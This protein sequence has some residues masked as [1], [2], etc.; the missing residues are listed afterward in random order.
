MVD[1]LRGFFCR[2]V[3]RKK[4]AKRSSFPALWFLIE[5]TIWFNRGTSLFLRADSQNDF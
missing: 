3:S 5:N 2:S 4:Y 1:F